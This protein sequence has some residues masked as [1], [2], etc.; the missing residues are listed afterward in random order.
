MLEYHF[1]SY[2]L[3]EIYISIMNTIM[4]S[5]S[6]LP[7]VAYSTIEPGALLLQ[8][9]LKIIRMCVVHL[10]LSLDHSDW[11]V[12]QDMLP[13]WKQSNVLDTHLL[14]FIGD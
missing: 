3:K 10:V 2:G 1:A 4:K 14:R 6:S 9:V 13:A 8:Y 12:W 5:T 7:S 11:P